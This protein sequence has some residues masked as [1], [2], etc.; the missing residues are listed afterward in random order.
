MHP[1]E[2]DFPRELARAA[3]SF[4][5]SRLSWSSTSALIPEQLRIGQGWCLFQENEFVHLVTQSGLITYNPNT[6][7]L[8]CVWYFNLSDLRY[9]NDFIN[10]F[11]CSW[12][13]KS[14][15]NNLRLR[16]VTFAGSISNIF[17]ERIFPAHVRPLFCVFLRKGGK[18]KH[19]KSI[20]FERL[21]I[22]DSI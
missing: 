15:A 10:N 7:T 1:W 19:C 8:N 22:N 3:F 21:Y 2:N 9:K 20:P 4:S 17:P 14:I 18:N 12:V 5:L 11:Y 16:C 13:D 6:I